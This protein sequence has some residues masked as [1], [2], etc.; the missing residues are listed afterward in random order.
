MIE[1]SISTI[2][3]EEV[4]SDFSLYA[5]FVWMYSW[6]WTHA[7]VS[8]CISVRVYLPRIKCVYIYYNIS[9]SQLFFTE[10]CCV[11]ISNEKEFYQIGVILNVDG[12]KSRLYVRRR[13]CVYPLN[14]NYNISAHCEKPCVIL[15]V[16]AWT[17]VAICIV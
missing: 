17:S 5:T 13:S 11:R 2:L 9:W 6:L 15:N 1:E 10:P 3:W 7:R 12:V 4:Q 8:E 14:V 16:W